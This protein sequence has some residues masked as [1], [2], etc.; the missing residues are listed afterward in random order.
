MLCWLIT[1]CT[2]ARL[3]IVISWFVWMLWT[4]EEVS[5]TDSAGIRER[6]RE[7]G[8]GAEVSLNDSF[9]FAIRERER[10]TGAEVSLNDSF[11]FAIR[12]RE[13]GAEGGS[14]SERLTESF[15]GNTTER[16]NERTTLFG[17]LNDANWFA[18]TNHEI[19]HYLMLHLGQTWSGILTCCCHSLP[20]PPTGWETHTHTQTQIQTQTHTITHTFHL[21]RFNHHHLS[22]LYLTSDFV[23]NSNIGTWGSPGFGLWFG[24]K[25][26]GEVAGL[27]FGTAPVWISSGWHMSLLQLVQRMPT[28][29]NTRCIAVREYGTRELLFWKTVGTVEPVQA[30]VFLTCIYFL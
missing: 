4:R 26:V 30:A 16:T 28:E 2:I 18:E 11:S 13:R 19:H 1:I 25:L 6:E 17:E 24:F 10:G 29:G 12:E 15:T 27:M 7:R 21:P 20:S 8:T 5:L 23:Q 14:E 3:W 9:S 22:Q